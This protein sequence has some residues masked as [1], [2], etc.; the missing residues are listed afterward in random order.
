MF[1]R[2][3][4]SALALVALSAP[5]LADVTPA[6]VWQGWVDYYQKNG[7][8]VTEG[9]RDEAADRL[10]VK[11]A[12]FSFNAPSATV[13]FTMP[14]I[15]FAATGD[16]K[17]KA[18]LPPS[19]SAQIETK[20]GEDKPVTMDATIATT[21]AEIV[22][23][24]T[25]S[26]MTSVTS[27][28]NMAITLN[29]LKADDVSFDKPMT[30]TMADI[31]ANQHIVNAGAMDMTYDVKTG[32]ADLNADFTGKDKQGRDGTIKFKWGTDSLATDGTGKIPA[33]ADMGKEMAAAL[34]A[35][36]NLKGNFQIGAQTF[37]LDMDLPASDTGEEMAEPGTPAT[38]PAAPAAG[39]EDKRTQV[40]LT[41]KADGATGSM[42]LAS[43]GL[44]YQVDSDAMSVEM[45]SSDVPFPVKYGLNNVSMNLAMPVS[46]SDQAQPF[47]LAYS[48]GGLTLGDELWKMVDAES[49]LPHD[50]VDLDIDVTGKALLNVDLMDEK[51]MA[52]LENAENPASPGD[53]T[54][55]TINQIALKALGA[56]VFAKGALTSEKG[57]SV[58]EPVGT[59]NA[60][61]EG[62]NGLIDKLVAAGLVPQDQVQGVRMMLMMFAKPET[63]GKDVLVTD[64]EFK[65][66]GQVFANGQ[67]VK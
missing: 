1:L 33:G 30:L 52:E 49:K 57:M 63:E 60:R 15:D 58:S 35:G 45:H 55:L 53:V 13:K 14:Q 29:S 16:G 38:E 6:D 8:T 23:S 7:Y 24:G 22:S 20:D 51:A 9:S 10:T 40:K 67:Q 17:V 43:E 47:K 4:T 46:K 65:E 11:D 54:E 3:K 21:G 28:G 18:T 36:L 50:P 32:R 56:S 27:I 66:G 5:A 19:M 41:G 42:G 64:L 2:A 44:Q 48:I 26:D 31:K 12:V 39:A 62:V 25:P 37:D 34:R 59:I 61:Y